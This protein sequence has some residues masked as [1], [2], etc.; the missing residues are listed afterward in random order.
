[1]RTLASSTF[2][3]LLGCVS[4]R[5]DQAAGIHGPQAPSLDEVASR[6][7]SPVDA[8]MEV[9]VGLYR[10]TYPWIGTSVLELRQDGSWDEWATGNSPEEPSAHGVWRANTASLFLRPSSSGDVHTVEEVRYDVFPDVGG[11]LTLV[12]AR[13]IETFGFQGLANAVCLCRR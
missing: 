12:D 2:T 5:H 1:M 11:T 10:V 13:T 3:C 4:N 8:D 9:F 6:T 7:P